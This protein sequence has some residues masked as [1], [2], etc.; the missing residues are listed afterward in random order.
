MDSGGSLTQVQRSGRRSCSTIQGDRVRRNRRF[1][2]KRPEHG[3]DTAGQSEYFPDG[4]RPQDHCQAVRARCSDAKRRLLKGLLE[5]QR[6]RFAKSARADSTA[7]ERR[8]K[9]RKSSQ[10]RKRGEG[11]GLD[12]KTSVKKLRKQSRRLLHHSEFHRPHLGVQKVGA[13]CTDS[14]QSW[15]DLAV[16]AE[17]GENCIATLH[18]HLKKLPVHP[19]Y[20]SADPEFKCCRDLL[21]IP[22]SSAKTWWKALG[23]Q[24]HRAVCPLVLS[25]SKAMLLGLNFLLKH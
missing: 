5:R 20:D 19:D 17:K 3:I 11:S 13:I 10:R 15:V 12:Q 1:L 23:R 2:G 21:P 7:N 14:S 8:S 25:S 24:D 18:K 6:R 22:F 16:I 4:V 9:G